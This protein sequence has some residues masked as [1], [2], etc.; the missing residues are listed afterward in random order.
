MGECSLF[1]L[2]KGLDT[3]LLLAQDA[4]KDV[5]EAYIVDALSEAGVS[6]SIGRIL[7]DRLV[8]CSSCDV[9][10]CDAA[11]VIEDIEPYIPYLPVEQLEV[12]EGI[13]K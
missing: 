9:S 5:P 11:D 3:S 8:E 2:A 6:M 10:G 13:G 4:F 1:D 7:V 12:S